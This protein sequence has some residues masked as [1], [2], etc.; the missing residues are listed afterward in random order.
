MTA[1]NRTDL[2]L[3]LHSRFGE[4]RSAAHTLTGDARWARLVELLTDWPHEHLVEVVIPY[5]EDLLRDDDSPRSAPAHW[6]EIRDEQLQIHPA[7]GLARSC[8]P[9]G[10]PLK[11]LIVFFSS[12][13]FQ[14][15][16]KLDLSNNEL[17][18]EGAKTLASSPHLKNLTTLQLWDNQIG[19]QGA[20]ALAHAAHLQR[21]TRLDLSLNEIGAQGAQAL[22]RSTPLKNLT[23]LDLSVNTIGDEGAQ[24]LARSLQLHKLTSLHLSYNDIGPQGAKALASS[25]HLKRLTSLEL[26]GNPIGEEGAKALASSPHLAEPIR[27]QWRL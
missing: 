5:L 14:H 27:A 19:A 25:P 21:L 4:L 22:A 26:S 17:G 13:S 1:A 20:Q 18:D 6:L 15:I 23:G 10:L 2:A 3:D 8:E 12:P 16:T 11:H 24:A 9:L 7:F